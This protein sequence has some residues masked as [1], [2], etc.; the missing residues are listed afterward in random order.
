[1][2]LMMSENIAQNMYSSQ[3]TINYP[4]QLLLIG[5]S[6][7]L[8][9]PLSLSIKDSDKA[10]PMSFSIIYITHVT[11]N[12]MAAQNIAEECSFIQIACT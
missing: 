5:Y 11:P 9:R 6:R 10:I 3:G 2:L 1:M 8:D 12:A 7:K 4:T